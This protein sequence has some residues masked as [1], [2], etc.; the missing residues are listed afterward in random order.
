V[1]ATKD[2][3]YAGRAHWGGKSGAGDLGGRRER[4]LHAQ[5]LCPVRVT[6]LVAS[7]GRYL[8]KGEARTMAEAIA[9]LGGGRARLNRVER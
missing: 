4:K 2:A 8:S 1:P 9:K 6:A 3:P 7:P 5:L